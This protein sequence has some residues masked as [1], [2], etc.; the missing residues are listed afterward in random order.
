[1]IF[2]PAPDCCSC[3]CLLVCG[4]FLQ[5]G[6]ERF[7]CEGGGVMFAGREAANRVQQLRFGKLK[8]LGNH[9]P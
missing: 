4:W 6:L 1:M 9:L 7:D 5:G 3:S 2:L 8:D